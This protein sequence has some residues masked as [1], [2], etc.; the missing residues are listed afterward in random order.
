MKGTSLLAAAMCAALTLVSAP[1]GAAIYLATLTGTTTGADYSDLFFESE[2]PVHEFFDEEFS[3][4]Y[5]L[6]SEAASSVQ[7]A[8][9]TLNG[10]TRAFPP[11]NL[12]ASMNVNFPI[13]F[14]GFTYAE[15]ANL[16]G[17]LTE[18]SV[19]ASITTSTPAPAT[20]FTTGSW[21]GTGAGSFLF[22]SNGNANPA[23]DFTATG[24]L[25]VNTLTIARVGDITA[26][27]EPATW[28]L[29]IGG[30]GLA[31]ASLRKRRGALA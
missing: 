24:E 8:S 12:G 22:S 31:G 17:V 16:G 5:T 3:L 19:N 1:A 9:L 30:F 23:N 15:Q 10:V 7:G 18:N 11:A 21:S 2:E 13:S 29:M 6:D 14:V 4:T 25:A 28:A 26:V 20:V 27:P